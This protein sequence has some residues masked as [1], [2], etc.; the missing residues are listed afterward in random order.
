VK[1]SSDKKY[2]YDLNGRRISKEAMLP[3]GI[4]IVKEGGKSRKVV[5]R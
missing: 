3:R 2:Y 1:N 4:Y 5:K